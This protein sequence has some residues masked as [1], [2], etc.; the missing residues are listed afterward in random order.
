MPI[1]SLTLVLD[2]LCI[3][4]TVK[5][6]TK[7]IAI[8]Q[9]PARLDSDGTNDAAGYAMI[10]RAHEQKEQEALD[11]VAG[12]TGSKKKTRRKKK[13]KNTNGCTF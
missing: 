3:P 4:L 1:D 5:E 13:I 8:L 6:R 11:D 12:E 2:A 9:R 7:V 10:A